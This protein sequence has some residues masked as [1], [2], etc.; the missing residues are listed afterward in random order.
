MGGF[1]ATANLARQGRFPS[2]SV[3]PNNL[4]KPVIRLMYSDSKCALYSLRRFQVSSMLGHNILQMTILVPHS[5]SEYHCCVDF[6]IE[7]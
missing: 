3:P 2:T 7:E 1:W 5:G 4:S 6:H